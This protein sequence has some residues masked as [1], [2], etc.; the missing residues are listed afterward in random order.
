MK[1]FQL[2]GKL[3]CS[4]FLLGLL[5]LIGSLASATEIHF[6]EF[7]VSAGLIIINYSLH[8]SNMVKK[9]LVIIIPSII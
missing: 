3:C 5:A 7:V 2:S 1:T 9:Q 4:W 6:H 8:F